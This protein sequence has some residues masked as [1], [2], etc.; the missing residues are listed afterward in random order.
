MTTRVVKSNQN[1]RSSKALKPL[2]LLDF[3][4]CSKMDL[5]GIEPR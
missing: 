3:L 4:R 5:R 2:I 1:V